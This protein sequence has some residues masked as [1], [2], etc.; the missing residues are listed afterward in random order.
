[1]KKKVIFLFFLI[2]IS[3]IIFVQITYKLSNSGN[4][5]NK[6]DSNNIFNISSY[7]A[8]IEVEVHSNKNTNKY[9]LKQQYVEPNIFKQEVIEPE[10]IKGLKSTFDGNNLM[11]ENSSI[12]VKTLY[13]NY[14]YTGGNSLSLNSFI[15]DYLEDTS[16]EVEETEKE[17]VIK[18]KV[19]ESKNKYEMYKKIYINKSTN[20]PTKMEI[21]DVN[22]NTTVYILYREIKINKIIKEDI[23]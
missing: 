21:L 18:V 1:V 20:L 7:E 11:L 8:I 13:E 15:E 14:K 12:G 23:L 3:I 17:T 19:L 5:I 10:N 6:S 22:Q 9:V 4:N 2:L 16:P